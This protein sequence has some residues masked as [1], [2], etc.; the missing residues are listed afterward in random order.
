MKNHIYTYVIIQAP[1]SAID[2]ITEAREKAGQYF[3]TNFVSPV[4]NSDNGQGVNAFMIMADGSEDGSDN[5]HRFNEIRRK[6][7]SW[8]DSQAGSDGRNSLWY[9]GSVIEQE[10]H[11][12]QQLAVS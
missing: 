9:T 7:I 12:H 10:M 3:G 6:Y 4:M 11:Y 5:F 1:V 2:K 8:I